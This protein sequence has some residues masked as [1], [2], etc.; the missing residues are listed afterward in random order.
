MGLTGP[1]EELSLPASA[2]GGEI[3]VIF[4]DQAR[5]Q[6]RAVTPDLM[7]IISSNLQSMLHAQMETTLLRAYGIAQAYDYRFNLMK[8]PD[9]FPLGHDSL[10]FDPGEMRALF[11]KGRTLG[12]GPSSWLTTPP[13]GQNISPWIIKIVSELRD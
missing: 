11:E 10:A 3:Y 9:S 2:G 8:I 13:A 12:R 5:Q 7:G 6:P 4:N 1:R